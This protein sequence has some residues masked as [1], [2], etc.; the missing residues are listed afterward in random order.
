MVSTRACSFNCFCDFPKLGPQSILHIY[1][2]AKKLNT[3]M[4][5][6]PSTQ[7]GSKMLTGHK[8]V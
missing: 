3:L 8:T 6:A 2:D 5:M 7:I 1:S 4:H